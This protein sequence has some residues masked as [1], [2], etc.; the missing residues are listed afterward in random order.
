MKEE[1]TTIPL[2]LKNLKKIKMLLEE[3]VQDEVIFMVEHYVVTRIR[4]DKPLSRSLT[5][6]QDHLKNRETKY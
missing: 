6:V 3:L 4:T 2:H 1:F 5:M